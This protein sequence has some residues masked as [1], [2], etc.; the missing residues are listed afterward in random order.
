MQM[1][2][3]RTT[4]VLGNLQM[5]KVEVIK[6]EIAILT[7]WHTVFITA[8]TMALRGISAAQH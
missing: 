8:F 4:A 5:L 3:R 1:E 7:I 6:W 2:L